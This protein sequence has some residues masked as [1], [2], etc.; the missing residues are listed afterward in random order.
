MRGEF[1]PLAVIAAL[2]KHGVHYVVIGGFAA[3][4]HGAPVVTTDIDIIYE[5]TQENVEQLVAALADLDA[6]YRHQLGRHIEPNVEVLM[7]TSGGGHHLFETVA[8]D[9][10]ALRESSELGYAELIPNSVVY[11]VDGIEV[12]FA[13]LRDIIEMKEKAGRDKDRAALPMLRAVLDE[14]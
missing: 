7:S 1:D 11:E 4:M 13:S 12:R 8:G 5:L 10:D 14:D 6:I 9:I 2:D 3:W